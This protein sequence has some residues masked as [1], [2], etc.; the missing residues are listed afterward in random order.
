MPKDSK[1]YLTKKAF[2]DKVLTLYG[3][4]AVMEALNDE[5]LT[6]HKLHLSTSNH[7]TRS[8]G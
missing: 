6:I 7:P 8:T 4:H 5:S 2:F 3:R 1:A